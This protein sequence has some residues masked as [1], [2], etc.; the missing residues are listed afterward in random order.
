MDDKIK[1]RK[2]GNVRKHF[3]RKYYVISMALDQ[4][5]Y[6]EELDVQ[7]FEELLRRYF[8]RDLWW[9]ASYAETQLYLAE[10]VVLGLVKF[11]IENTTDND[12]NKESHFISI[13]ENGLEALRS[14][15][16]HSIS[17]Q[18]FMAQESRRL[19]VIAI[20]IAIIGVLCAICIPLFR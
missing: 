5:K 15:T 20:I 1:Y 3:N 16:Y 2:E 7:E 9:N 11:R 14:Q 18:L 6:S 12:E 13:T 17:A 8:T 19:S 10:M 4:L